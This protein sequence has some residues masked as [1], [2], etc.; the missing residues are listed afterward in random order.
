MNPKTIYIL[1]H[2][3]P[4]FN[5][6]NRLMNFA[7]KN[8]CEEYNAHPVFAFYYDNRGAFRTVL[9]RVIL[10]FKKRKRSKRNKLIQ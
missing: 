8:I 3:D 4:S 5:F 1:S 6:G 7:I 2:N 9:K 10:L